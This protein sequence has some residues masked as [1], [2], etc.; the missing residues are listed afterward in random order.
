MSFKID[1]LLVP[2]SEYLTGITIKD[3]I[4]DKQMWPQE[5]L[6]HNKGKVIQSSII[7]GSS[8]KS[9]R[10][11]E[12]KRVKGVY[13]LRNVPSVKILVRGLKFWWLCH[14]T[15]MDLG[16]NINFCIVKEILPFL[17]LY[18]RDHPLKWKV[19][20][21]NRSVKCRFGTFKNSFR[22]GK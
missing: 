22:Q 16:G 8:T 11:R 7:V 3:S 6:T 4:E 10:R 5:Y 17:V 18:V 2:G 12:G 14:L 20:I 9:W 15:K 1:F 13:L 21:V 19:V